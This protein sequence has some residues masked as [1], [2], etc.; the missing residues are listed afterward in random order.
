[1]PRVLCSVHH[2]GIG[3]TSQGLRAGRPTVI[4]P[5]AHD[6]FDNAAR[7]KRLR[8]SQTV[9]ASEFSV[10]TLVAA[11]RRVVDD[12]RCVQS[13]REVGERMRNEDGGPVAAKALEDAMRTTRTVPRSSALR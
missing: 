12:P 6:Q 10:E 11:I 1:M 9:P 4:V 2:G 5:H 8:V 3:T 13:A 7:V